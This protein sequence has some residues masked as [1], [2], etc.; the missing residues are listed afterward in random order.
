[1]KNEIVDNI[2]R[3]SK[4]EMMRSCEVESFGGI[5]CIHHPTKKAKYRL[6]AAVAE[7]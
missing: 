7:G 2:I 5:K 6:N 1:M 4:A 3:S